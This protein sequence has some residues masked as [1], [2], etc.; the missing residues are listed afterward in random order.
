MNRL[1]RVD[2]GVVDDNALS[3]DFDEPSRGLTKF[4]SRSQC[5]VQ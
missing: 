2:V 5:N 1:H 4:N 3:R